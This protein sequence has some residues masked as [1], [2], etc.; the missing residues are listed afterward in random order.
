MKLRVRLDELR[1][2]RWYS[3]TYR[4]RTVYTNTKGR[5]VIMRGYRRYLRNDDSI[6]VNY[7][8][9]GIPDRFA[10]ERGKELNRE[11][12]ADELQSRS[13]ETTER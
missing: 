2:G 8:W 12:G 9:Y 3:T 6:E 1:N 11:W 4:T 5:Y 10:T 7:I 13:S